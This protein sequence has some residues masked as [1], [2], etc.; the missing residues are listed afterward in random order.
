MAKK[1]SRWERFKAWFVNHETHT[2]CVCGDEFAADVT[3]P[4]LYYKT[5]RYGLIEKDWVCTK[6]EC[7]D[8]ASRREREVGGW[9]GAHET[10]FPGMFGA[11]RF[12]DGSLWDAQTNATPAQ[13]YAGFTSGKPP[14][15]SSSLLG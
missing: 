9:I 1:L 6:Q 13:R 8:V 15:P 12:P 14:R 3:W 5:V 11:H 4:A 7:L 2:C 10:A